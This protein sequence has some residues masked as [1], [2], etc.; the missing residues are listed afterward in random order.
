MKPRT[1]DCRAMCGEQ[2]LVWE[3]GVAVSTSLGSTSL[4]RRVAVVTGAGGGSARPRQSAWPPRRDGHRQRSRIAALE[5]SD[6]VDVVAA[7]GGRAVPSRRHRRFGHRHEIVRT[8]VDDLGRDI[9]VTTPAY[10]RQR[11]C[12]PPTRTGIWSVRCT[13]AT[14]LLTRNAAAHGAHCPQTG[15]PVNGSIINTASEA[16]LLGPAAQANYGGR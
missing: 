2:V 5:R 7:A 14:L 10:P 15:E 1:P 8:A 4:G 12:S 16:A 11:C 13:C 3:R 6:V 9:V